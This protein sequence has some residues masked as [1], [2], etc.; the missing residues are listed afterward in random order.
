MFRGLH[1]IYT[2]GQSVS[3]ITTLGFE[4]VRCSYVGPLAYKWFIGSNYPEIPNRVK[5]GPNSGGIITVLTGH[6]RIQE[7]GF[8]VVYKTT[9]IRERSWKTT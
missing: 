8:V 7:F 4:Y 1:I 6:N 2:W 5:E 3:H 9:M